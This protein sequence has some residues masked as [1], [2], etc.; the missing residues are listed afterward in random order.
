MKR[1][2][3]NN[4]FQIRSEVT[5]QYKMESTSDAHVTFLQDSNGFILFNLTWKTPTFHVPSD[6]IDVAIVGKVEYC[7]SMT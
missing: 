4:F 1:I 5:C 3:I 7:C 6:K 2:V